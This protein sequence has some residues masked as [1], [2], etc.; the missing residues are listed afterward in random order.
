MSD[1]DT[2][3]DEEILEDLIRRDGPPRY[4]GHV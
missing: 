1:P 3:T 4:T 2:R